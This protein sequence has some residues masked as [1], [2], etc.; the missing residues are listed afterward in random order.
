M[1]KENEMSDEIKVAIAIIIGMISIAFI[2]ALKDHAETMSMKEAG[3]VWK[4]TIQG[5]W[6]KAEESE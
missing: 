6:I 2:F 4:P 3:Y 5:H 1:N